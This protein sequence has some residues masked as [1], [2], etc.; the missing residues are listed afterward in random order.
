MSSPSCQKP[1]E[2]STTH[3]IGRASRAGPQ[4]AS[5][6]LALAAA[7]GLA[8]DPASKAGREN[9]VAVGA[10]LEG[11]AGVN[12]I[13]VDVGRSDD[14]GSGKGAGNKESHEGESRELHLDGCWLGGFEELRVFCWWYVGRLE[15]MIDAEDE[16]DER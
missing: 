16:G 1:R 12:D 2:V 7:V 4:I 13:G 6:L 14:G 3:H 9:L 11:T 15:K 8:L 10:A 5:L